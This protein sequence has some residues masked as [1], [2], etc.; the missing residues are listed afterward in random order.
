MILL[1]LI[2]NISSC[3]CAPTFV[4]NVA[5]SS[6]QVEQNHNI[7]LEWTF[8]TRPQGSWTKL[9]VICSRLAPLRA[10]VLY[11]VHDGVEVSES[12]D[13]QFSGR[14]QMDKDVLREGRIRF[15]ISRLTTGDSGLY[16]CN[17]RTDYGEGFAECCV[18]VTVPDFVKIKKTETVHERNFPIPTLKDETIDA[19]RWS[20]LIPHFHLVFFIIF[21]I[22]FIICLI[23]YIRIRK[24]QLKEGFRKIPSQASALKIVCLAHGQTCIDVDG[25]D[26][27][28]SLL[29]RPKD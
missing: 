17:I 19:G 11:Q 27:K 25:S 9:D 5:Q 28:S 15:H 4:V 20:R 13:E 3:L 14:V 18:T 12:L 6:Y 16:V 26:T 2:I 29:Q 8:T 24:K 21:I 23:V 7:T 22:I 1:L 10:S